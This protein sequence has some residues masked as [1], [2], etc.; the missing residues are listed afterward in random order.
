[1]FD[2]V[3]RPSHYAEGR[4]HEPIDVIEDWGLGY[5]LGSALKYISRAGR[6]DAALMRQDIEKAIW[7]LKR[8]S[9]SLIEEEAQI[10]DAEQMIER[11]AED[12]PTLKKDYQGP[13]Y[14]KHPD[15]ID[16]EEVEFRAMA[17]IPYEPV[18]RVRKTER[19]AMAE[20]GTVGFGVDDDVVPFSVSYDDLIEFEAWDKGNV[21][22]ITK[23]LSKFGDKDIVETTIVDGAVLGHQKNGDVVVLRSAAPTAGVEL[24][25]LPS[26]LEP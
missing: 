24:D 16:Q 11:R 9:D 20:L 12:L 15:L 14:A 3:Q 23:D 22:P 4:T 5:H 17:D 10:K 26:E 7:Y 1:M 6:K 21:T 8:F 2:P 19:R 13:L 18:A 25:T